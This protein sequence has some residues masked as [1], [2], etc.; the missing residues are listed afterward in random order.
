[1]KGIGEKIKKIRE[2]KNYT[3]DYMAG[4]LGISQN[5]Y[6]KI[7]TGGIKL[8][9]DRLNAIA[10]VLEV[11]PESI[12]TG[13]LQSFHFDNTHIEKFYAYIE[14]LQEDNK[15]FLKLLSDQVKYLQNENERLLKTVET[16]TSKLI[17]K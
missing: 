10:K 14:N 11:T 16:L 5:T 8:T 15:E 4:Q 12:L 2:T 13:D 3:Q 7:E 9:T 1:M 17:S 6:S